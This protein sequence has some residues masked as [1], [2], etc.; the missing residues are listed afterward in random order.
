MRLRGGPHVCQA[1]RMGGRGGG[2]AARRKLRG[3]GKFHPMPLDDTAG[4]QALAQM[5]GDVWE[6][7][8]VLIRRTQARTG[9]RRARRI[10]RQ[11]HVQSVASCAAAHAPPRS[12]TSAKPTVPFFRRTLAGS[13]WNPLAKG[14]A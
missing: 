2:F 8:A 13:S 7:T 10:Q 12:H 9:E 11:I 3:S 1:S 5:F 4:V 14:A 6:W